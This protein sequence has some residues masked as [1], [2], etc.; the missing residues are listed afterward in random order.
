ML[1]SSTLFADENDRKEIERRMDM[2]VDSLSDAP[3]YGAREKSDAFWS[4]LADVNKERVVKEA[5]K[6]LAEPPTRLTSSLYHEFY[7][8]GNRDHYQGPYFQTIAQMNAFNLAERYENQGRFIEPL[9]KA[10]LAFCDLPSWLLPAHDSNAYV[11]DGKYTYSDLGSTMLGAQMAIA[12]NL[13]ADKLPP[14]TVERAKN[15]IERRLLQPYREAVDNADL[16]GMFWLRIVSNWNAVCHAGT[17]CAALNT[18]DSK[19]ERAFFLAAADYFSEKYFLPSFTND[20]YCSEGLGYWNYGFG[21]Y[22]TLGAMARNATK[23]RLDMFRFPKI[24]AI[25]DFGPNQELYNKNFVAF[26]DCGTWATPSPLYTGYLSRLKG[27]GYTEYE[28]RELGPNFYAG[29]PTIVFAF[30]FDEKITL[31]DKTTSKAYEPPLRSDFPD[32]CVTI[33]RPNPNTTGAYLAAA[34]KGGNNNELHNHNDLGSYTLIAGNKVG[35]VKDVFVVRDPGA[36]TYTARTFGPRRYEGELLNSHGH[37]VPVVAGKLQSPG[38]QAQGK[39]LSKRFNYAIDTVAYD[40]ASAYD[41]PELQ[42]LTR[43]FEYGRSA[44]DNAGFFQ[45]SDAVVFEPGKPQDFE[46]A[47][48]TFEEPAITCYADRIE[49]KIGIAT[50]TVTA[51]DLKGNWARLETYTSI[52]GEK[53]DSVPNKPTRVAFKLASPIESCV[54]VQR[55]EI[56]D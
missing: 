53:D 24:R 6:F 40:L 14:A 42:R 32:A 33:C 35:N 54:I 46:T 48:V 10:I 2:I 56:A 23:G 39:P 45:I 37:P 5:E 21:N 26:A 12:L 18:L 34:F 38:A 4:H 49:V 27:Y 29:D 28:N 25:L 7:G 3:N 19:K 20:G 51:H 50:L 31:A 16:P 30:A 1:T 36:E 52:V 43:T 9:N 17:I 47:I 41:V 15:E 55:F 11:W 44:R 22:I 8:T 13:H